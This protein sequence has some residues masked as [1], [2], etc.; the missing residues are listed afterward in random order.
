MSRKTLILKLK[1][2]ELDTTGTKKVLSARLL[3]AIVVKGRKEK[4]DPRDLDDRQPEKWSHI[5]N[6]AQKEAQGIEPRRVVLSDCFQR[7]KE[8][9][10]NQLMGRQKLTE[11]ARGELYPD[12][13]SDLVSGCAEIWRFT[14]DS[15][16]SPTRCH[17]SS[18]CVI[19]GS[20]TFWIY[21]RAIHW[22]AYTWTPH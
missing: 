4:F 12:N 3:K 21:F 8:W 7:S 20:H 2:H 17:D 15:T 13:E 18:R 1:S 19:R 10:N 22:Y 14:D 11:V 16:F 9:I 6:L 5:A